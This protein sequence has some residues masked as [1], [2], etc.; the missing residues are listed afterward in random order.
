METLSGEAVS[1]RQQP[2]HPLRRRITAA[3]A[4]LANNA[5]GLGSV[6]SGTVS[7]FKTNAIANNPSG[8]GRRRRLPLG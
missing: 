4:I 2:F 3:T 7:F 8:M 5:I 6:S 1:F